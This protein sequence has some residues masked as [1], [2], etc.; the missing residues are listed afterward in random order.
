M[1][2]SLSLCVC[3]L[4]VCLG[5]IQDR[6]I[7]QELMDTDLHQIINSA[8]QLTGEHVQYFMYQVRLIPSLYTSIPQ[9]RYASLSLYFFFRYVYF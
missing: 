6:Y 8:N 5:L 2:V 4:S 3:L 7:V 1:Y 9:Y